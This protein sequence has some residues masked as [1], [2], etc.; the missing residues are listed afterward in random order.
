MSYV[1]VAHAMGGGLGSGG[2]GGL[3][4]QFFP[5]IL[6]LVIFYF[7]LIR[8]QRKQAQRHQD[9]IRNLKIGDRVVTSGGIHGEVKGLTDSTLTLEIA[10]KVRIKITRGSIA[11]TSQD[12]ISEGQKPA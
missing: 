5:I 1:G 3:M 10:D 12:A 2:A 9:F 4:S 8:P 6:I 11:G 7:I